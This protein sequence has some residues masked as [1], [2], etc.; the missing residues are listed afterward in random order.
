[1]S[2]SGIASPAIQ[3]PA[4]QLVAYTGAQ[5]AGYTVGTVPDGWEVQ[6][7]N[8]FALVIARQGNPDTDI[9]SF[10]G[11]LVVMLQSKDESDRTDGTKVAVGS[12]TG[13]IVRADVSMVDGVDVPGDPDEGRLFFTDSV[14]HRLVIQVPAELHWTNAQF[15]AFG[16]SVHAN[17]N[18]EAG[19]G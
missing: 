9:N 1:V 16:S 10:E 13:T 5:P 8:N 7:V 15:I 14:G 4:I 12:Q 3:S 17:A 2:T 19:R 11:K 6:G 18:A